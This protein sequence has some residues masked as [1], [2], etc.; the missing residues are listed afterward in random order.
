MSDLIV[1]LEALK[2]YGSMVLK[3]SLPHSP[4]ARA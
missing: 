1:T 4:G 2:P 3:T